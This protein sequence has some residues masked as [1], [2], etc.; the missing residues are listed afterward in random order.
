MTEEEFSNL[1]IEDLKDNYR[2]KTEEEFVNEFGQNFQHETVVYFNRSD[3]CMSQLYGMSLNSPDLR[4]SDKGRQSMRVRDLRI[5][6]TWVVTYDML[7]KITDYY[8]LNKQKIK[9]KDVS[10]CMFKIEV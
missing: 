7:I 8:T 3:N 2:F 6:N 9:D 5:P 1:T 10:K 4:I